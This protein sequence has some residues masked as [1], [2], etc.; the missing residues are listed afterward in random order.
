M[1]KLRFIN[2]FIN[3]LRLSVQGSA[4]EGK[5]KINDCILFVNSLD[6]RDVDRST[7]LST[8]KSAGSTVSLVVRYV[9][10]RLAI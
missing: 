1:L 3:A 9:K 8:L 5:L 7:V 10:A 6:C 4:L 2:A